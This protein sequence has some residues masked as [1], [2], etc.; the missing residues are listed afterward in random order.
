M[1][2][3]FLS[4]IALSLALGCTDTACALVG[5][6]SGL[7]VRLASVPTAPYRVEARASGGEAT[8]VFECTDARGGCGYP[9]FADFAPNV[10]YITISSGG[11]RTAAQELR[12]QFS[13]TYPNGERCGG[14]CRNATVT[15][16]F[17]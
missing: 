8:Y 4:G 7:H 2:L 14:A 6:V 1:R 16:T 15:A 5:C 3:R 17:P 12:P 9:F 11:R 13:T 10:V